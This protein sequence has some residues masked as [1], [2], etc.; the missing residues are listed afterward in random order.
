MDSKNQAS[1][2]V[3]QWSNGGLEQ[4]R[5][6]WPGRAQAQ[7]GKLYACFF[8]SPLHLVYAQWGPLLESGHVHQEVSRASQMLPSCCSRALSG[9]CP[10]RVPGTL[11]GM[12]AKSHLPR[13]AKIFAPL[14]GSRGPSFIACLV[15]A[16]QLKIFKWCHMNH[17]H[18]LTRLPSDVLPF[19]NTNFHTLKSHQLL[20]TWT[21]QKPKN[22]SNYG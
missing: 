6:N 18:F 2:S 11:Q 3:R 20:E 22:N 4:G 12:A 21:R 10:C 5:H 17:W 1:P 13:V 9:D 16:N 14:L 8:C 15:S 7:G 19:D